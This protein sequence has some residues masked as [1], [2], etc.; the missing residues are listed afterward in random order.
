MLL[1]KVSCVIGYILY[2]RFSVGSYILF[3]LFNSWIG[4]KS[5]TVSRSQLNEIL[6]NLIY[7]ISIY[8]II[9]VPATMMLFYH[10]I[11]VP[12]TMMLFYHII[13]APVTM[14]P[15]SVFSYILLSLLIIYQRIC[16]LFISIFSLIVPADSVTQFWLVPQVI[17]MKR[18]FKPYFVLES[19]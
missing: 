1:Q 15:I 11:H 12:A 8:H 19:F 5:V 16:H 7:H 3:V 4:S 10:I 18:M 2:I 13:H 17:L 6:S 9:S 14:M